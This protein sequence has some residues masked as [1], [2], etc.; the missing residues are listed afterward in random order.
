MILSRDRGYVF[1]H[2][3]KTGGTSLALALEDKAT[4]SDIMVGDTPKAKKRKGRVKDV[5]TRGRLWKHATLADIDGLITLEEAA[6]LCVVTLVRNPWDRMVSYYHWLRSKDFAHPAFKKAKDLPFDQFI[7]D[8]VIVGGF[9]GA[10]AVAYVTDAA[11]R[12]QGDIYLR[13]DRLAEDLPAFEDFLS[14]KLTMPHA[15]ASK[16]GAYQGYYRPQDVDHIARVFDD[17][18]ARFGFAFEP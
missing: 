3:P 1:L 2:A 6:S 11:G 4:A 16:R 17:D 5:K 7:Y 12:V 18:I 13:L 10:P 9:R 8:P 14:L 15:N